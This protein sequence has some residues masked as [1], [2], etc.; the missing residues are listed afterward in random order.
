VLDRRNATIAPC[1]AD[2][3]MVA[4][5]MMSGPARAC[6]GYAVPFTDGVIVGCFAYHCHAVDHEEKRTMGIAADLVPA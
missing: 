6:A 1:N 5:T 2:I 3:A 4:A